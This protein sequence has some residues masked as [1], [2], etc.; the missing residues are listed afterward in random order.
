MF[1]QKWT[2]RA[3]FT[4]PLLLLRN[5]SLGSFFGSFFELP[6]SDYKTGHEVRT[7]S[8]NRSSKLLFSNC[9]QA[10]QAIL[11]IFIDKKLREHWKV[12]DSKCSLWV[13]VVA[14][15]TK[16]SGRR[17]N[18]F[19]RQDSRSLYLTLS[20]QQQVKTAFCHRLVIVVNF[21]P[22]VKIRNL[23]SKAKIKFLM[24]PKPWGITPCPCLACCSCPTFIH[25]WSS[26]LSKFSKLWNE[27]KS[28]RQAACR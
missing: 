25:E 14:P 6:R 20:R 1:K 13:S 24:W 7:R 26:S 28:L 19:Q 9:S 22:K 4:L 27:S 10:I 16:V 18:T 21:F 17:M 15:Y 23:W 8:V 12:Q 5:I 3:I 11:A 2:L